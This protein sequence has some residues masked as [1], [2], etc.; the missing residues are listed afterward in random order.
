MGVGLLGPPGDKGDKGDTGSQGVKGDRGDQGP[1][2]DVGPQGPTGAIGAVGPQG[3]QGPTGATGPAGPQGLN[4][5]KGD[6]GPQGPTGATGA[7]G[8]AGPTGPMGPQGPQG[9]QGAV[10][11]QGQTGPAGAP[12]L[13]GLGFTFRGQ[14]DAAASYQTNDV[15]LFSGSVF[16]ATAD[17]IAITPGTDP[18]FW[19]LF[20]S[21]GDKGDKGDTGDPG[22]TGLTGVQGPQGATGP[23]GPQGP[24]GPGGE[25]TGG[26]VVA[27]KAVSTSCTNEFSQPLAVPSTSAGGRIIVT[28]WMRISIVHSA[29]MLD[30]GYVYPSASSSTDCGSSDTARSYWRVGATAP[31]DTYEITVPI[32]QLFNVGTSAATYTIYFNTKLLNTSGGSH[33]DAAANVDLTFVPN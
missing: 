30:R 3:L 28:G 17:N 5:D 27:N 15:V 26:G 12:G 1:Q 4:G 19:S 20:A 23:M 14:W 16:V 2:G 24:T 29:L 11:P 13:N 25:A 21:K 32:H 6:P 8:P 7:T 9:P 22:P 10:G 31:V 33:T 18:T